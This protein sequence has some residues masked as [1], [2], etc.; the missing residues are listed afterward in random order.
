MASV[1]FWIFVPMATIILGIVFSFIIYFIWSFIGNLF[2]KKGIPRGKNK[3]SEFIKENKDNL[4]D[5]GKE[6]IN[7]EEEVK[8][9]NKQRRKYREF[10]KLRR[11]D[12]KKRTEGKGKDNRGTESSSRRSGESKQSEGHSNV[13]AKS[14]PKSPKSRAKDGPNKPRVKLDG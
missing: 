13:S 6:K 11:A 5:P 3:V 4:L 14:D 2:I 8:H 1:W 7:K 10:D 12:L 9:A